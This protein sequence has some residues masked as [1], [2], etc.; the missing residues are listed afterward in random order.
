MATS[1]RVGVPE[2]AFVSVKVAVTVT[3]SPDLYGP[4]M[5]AIPPSV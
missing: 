4:V 1:E 5:L 2:I 3:L